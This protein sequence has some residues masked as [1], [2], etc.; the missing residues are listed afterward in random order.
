MLVITPPNDN[1]P[2]SR[3]ELRALIVTWQYNSTQENADLISNA[4]TSQ[5][6][7]M[8]YLFARDNSAPWNISDDAVL[9]DI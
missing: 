8:S 2:L 4:N 3:E 7:D 1:P 6:T 9:P 5:I